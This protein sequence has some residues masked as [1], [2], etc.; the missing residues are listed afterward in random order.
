MVGHCMTG[1]G[2]PRAVSR[3]GGSRHDV[4]RLPSRP[5]VVRRGL[6]RPGG[7]R[8][9]LG[10]AT[11]G[12]SSLGS[13]WP[14]S[15]ELGMVCQGER[16]RRGSPRCRSSQVSAGYG[17]SRFGKARQGSPQRMARCVVIGLAVV[18]LGRAPLRCAASRVKDR[19]GSVCPGSAMQ[20]VAP[21]S[22]AG[23][24]TA[25]CGSASRG[26]AWL[27]YGRSRRGMPGYG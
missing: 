15:P 10:M 6:S 7:S 11:R 22:T 20:V 14:G 8:L 1:H 13:V 5:G 21:L 24:G 18:G 26:T 19:L 2:S 27:P 23:P 16:A 12:L 17:K 4:A 3:R 9:N 25:R